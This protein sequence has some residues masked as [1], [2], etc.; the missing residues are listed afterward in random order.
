MV[1]ELD[2]A[3]VAGMVTL[4]N[5]EPAVVKRIETYV[6]QVHRLYVVDNSECVNHELIRAITD[7]Y[8]AAEYINNQGNQGI[9]NALNVAA[10]AALDGQ[11]TCLLMMD[12]DSEAPADLVASLYG[13]ISDPA[14]NTGIVSAQS[15][16]TVRRNDV[17]QVLTT[18]TSGSLLNLR[19]YQAV[20]PF[21]DEL[22]I[23]WVDHEYCFRL[24]E[25]GYRIVIANQVRLRHRLG[26]VKHKRLLGFL[27]IR[28]QSHSP[29]RL[30]YKFRNSLYVM[31]RYAKLLP[32][33]FVL[34]VCYELLRDTAKI[35][36]VE[37]HKRTY[38]AHV[39]KG[40]S[41][42]YR[43]QLGKLLS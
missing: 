29:T 41:D 24:V 23:D 26:K 6:Y 17:Q 1:T 35:T 14:N 10:R 7:R 37:N 25:H 43:K 16:A 40:L 30:Y 3:T 28:W 22:F 5:S 21:L 8:P 12:D 18:I 19:A 39:G 33:S 34:S 2:K 13:I 4:Y 11:F 9:A 15:D 32:P 36:F 20:G 31:N 27:S 42:A 38:W